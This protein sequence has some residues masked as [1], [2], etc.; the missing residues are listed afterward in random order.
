MKVHR[1]F[2]ALIPMLGLLA[3]AALG[4]PVAAADPVTIQLGAQNNSG[5][6]GTATL[7]DLG[8]N[9]TRVA[10]TVTGFQVG[11]PSPVH[12]HDGTC[13]TLN[14]AVKY[15]LTN[16]V[17][18]KSETTVPVALSAL[19]AQPHAINAHKSAQ[20]ATVYVA[21]GNITAAGG[22]G[23]QQPGALPTTGGGGMARTASPSLWAA[24]AA[25]LVF[26]IFGTT[27]VLRRRAHSLA[28]GETRR[29]R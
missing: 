19:L 22:T 24:V 2:Q 25:S 26:G 15:P 17:D 14:P 5:I 18:G 27:A 12:I 16:L 8:N 20:E 4:A 29:S 7:T 21:C 10:I 9:Q 28:T 6:T 13:A 1:F 3:F 23:G 11:T